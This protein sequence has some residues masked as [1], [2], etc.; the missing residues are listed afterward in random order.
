MCIPCTLHPCCYAQVVVVGASETGLACLEHL[1]LQ[2][3]TRF[4]N[5]T[6]LAPGGVRTDGIAR[7]FTPERVSRLGLHASVTTV[8]SH[9]VALDPQQQLLMLAD[10][11]HLTYDLLAIATGLQVSLA[12]TKAAVGEYMPS[13]VLY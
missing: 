13:F 2:P 3:D 10:G 8:D 11:A 6:L 4:T 1:L 12:V 7:Q 9:M 5:L